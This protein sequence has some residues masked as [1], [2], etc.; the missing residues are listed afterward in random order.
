[1]ARP[2]SNSSIIQVDRSSSAGRGENDGVEIGNG[3]ASVKRP[4]A[5]MTTAKISYS[6]LVNLGVF[7]LA[8]M[9]VQSA[10]ASSL[11]CSVSNKLDLRFD[12]SIKH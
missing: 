3:K 6:S 10:Q 12:Q 8:I 2:S 7:M 9:M 5:V 11:A 4:R 1:M